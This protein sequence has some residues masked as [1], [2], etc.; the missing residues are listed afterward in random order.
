MLTD[1][2]IITDI[3]QIIAQSR[4]NAVR[5]V[6]FQ[7]VLMYW[8]IGKRIF[9]EEQQGQERADY[10]AY[11]IKSLAQQLQPEFG[12]GF[13]ARQLERYRQFY[14]TF[15]I[16]S[17]LRTQLNWTQYKSLISIN[18][19]DKREFYI[20]ES[21]KNHW[22]SRQLERQINSSLYERLLLSNDKETVLAVANNQL[23]PSDPK[24]IIKDPMV[25][26]FLG[27]QRES[28]YYEK[29]LEQAII[30]HLQEFL[31]E[32]G[33]GFSFVAR[34]KRLHLD[35]DDFFVDL[36]LYNRLLQCFVIIEIK[37]HKL[38]HQDLGQLQMY[39]NYFDRVEKLPRE[40]PTIGI[41]LC[42]DKNDSVVKFSL[43]ENQQQIFA[44]QYQ[45]Y[46]PSEELLLTE[47]RKE[48]ENFEQK[49]QES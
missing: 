44:S 32:L 48:I 37:T 16:A 2:H 39:V 10:G 31:L 40:N 29:D 12:S 4:E 13:S 35:G 21:I 1:T 30:T 22:S 8:H 7:R 11:L 46:L 41:L 23:V 36:V 33:N 18:D 6:D 3:K 28:A 26:E 27:L 20:A 45:L 5:A 43:P 15:P 47:I 34:Q 42:A 17:A 24:H 9:E 25:L 19:P 49:Q 38:T 14:R